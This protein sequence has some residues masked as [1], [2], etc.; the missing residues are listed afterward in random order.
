MSYCSVDDVLHEFTP[1]LRKN[2]ERD[3]G[4]NL[5]AVIEGHI[6]KANAFVDASLARAYSVPLKSA[7]NIVISAE[8]KIAA[9]F[10][11]IAYSEKDEVVRD[12]Y[13]TAIMILDYLV[14]A[15][16]HSLVDD[17]LFS[18]ERELDDSLVLYGSDEK[19]F[20]SEELALW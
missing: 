11:A 13:E 20:T 12:K 10:A 3:Y 19:I 14:E 15:D 1:T 17:D 4:D 18:D 7:T 2:I 5:E 9:Y 16:K 6:Q 8:C